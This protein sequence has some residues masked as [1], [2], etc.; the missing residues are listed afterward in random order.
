MTV[1]TPSSQPVV[2]QPTDRETLEDLIRQ[3]RILPPGYRVVVTMEPSMMMRGA[4]GEMLTIWYGNEILTRHLR[5]R[6]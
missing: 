2:I 5:H 4:I 6:I 1:P 3:G